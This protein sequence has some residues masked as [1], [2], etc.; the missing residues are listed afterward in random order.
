VKLL[1]NSNLYGLYLLDAFK[2]FQ[3]VDNDQTSDSMGV[4][5]K[6]QNWRS[7]WMR[8]KKRRT[9][10]EKGLLWSPRGR[11]SKTSEQLRIQWAATG[12]RC[13]LEMQMGWCSW[14]YFKET[15][16]GFKDRNTTYS[17]TSQGLQ[18]CLPNFWGKDIQ[19]LYKYA[20][21]KGCFHLHQYE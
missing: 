12:N 15:P 6:L 13:P 17:R 3:S 2:L 9:S 7:S 19:Q 20:Q 10:L 11:L 14:H 5:E 16:K 4:S 18:T 21:W 1:L 8:N